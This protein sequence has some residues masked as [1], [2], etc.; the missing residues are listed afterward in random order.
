MGTECS[1]YGRDQECTQNFGRKTRRKQSYDV[2][3]V[4]GN[5]R[6]RPHSVTGFC[7]HGNELNGLH[8]LGSVLAGCSLRTTA[9]SLCH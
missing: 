8:K 1:T 3:V 6:G 5:E 9:V 7:E 4:E 2:G